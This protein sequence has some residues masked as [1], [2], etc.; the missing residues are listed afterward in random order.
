M[1]RKFLPQ[2]IL[3]LLFCVA[4]FGPA[5]YGQDGPPPNPEP[6]VNRPRDD[7]PNL[8]AQLGL[9]Q[10]QIQQFRKL[11]AE[12]RPLMNEAQR[13]L[14]DANRE[15]DMAI[16]ADSVS[17]EVVHAKLKVFQDA[18]AEVNRLRF[19]N[20]LNIRRILTQDQLVRF[21]DIRQHFAEMGGRKPGQNGRPGM[22]D[23]H[24]DGPP[25]QRAPGANQ[26]TRPASKEN[27]P[28]N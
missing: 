1:F 17:D 13:R 27:R 16:Y 8:M 3:G 4:F 26:L 14:R 2:T 7:R 6:G 18:Q 10:E 19:S 25:M 12:H 24:R 20:E 15:L 28:N 11:N 21:R 5:A 23:Q 9:S 22:G